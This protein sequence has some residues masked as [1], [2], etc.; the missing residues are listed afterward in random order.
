MKK[1]FLSGAFILA[2]AASAWALDLQ[3]ARSQGLVAEQPDGYIKAIDQGSEVN[4]LVN[5]VNSKRKKEYERISKEKGQ[6]VD[7]VGRLAAEQ[8]KNK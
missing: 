7:V 2:F 6:S 5:E 4:G 8:L 3:S 1:L